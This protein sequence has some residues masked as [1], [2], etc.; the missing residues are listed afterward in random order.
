[1]KKSTIVINKKAGALAIVL[2]MLSIV[3]LIG[4]TE[5]SS[6]GEAPPTFKAVFTVTDEA[7][8]PISNAIIGMNAGVA[9]SPPNRKPEPDGPFEWPDEALVSV[10]TIY[11]VFRTHRILARVFFTDISSINLSIV[12]LFALKNN[13]I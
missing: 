12:K 8:R 5:L 13:D 11:T 2:V 7:G 1:M 6:E 4:C 9:Y 10:G 3:C